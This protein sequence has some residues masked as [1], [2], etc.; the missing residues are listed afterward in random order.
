[1]A[2]WTAAPSSR[3][4]TAAL[5]RFVS[6]IA[7]ATAVGD[8]VK[9]VA[10]RVRLANR[11]C[12]LDQHQEGRLKRILGIARAAQQTAADMQHHRSVPFHQSGERGLVAPADK[13]PEQVSVGR[14]RFT[15]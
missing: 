6:S 7:A 5:T 2:L 4:G 10:Q 11:A 12:L 9:P 8:P 13:T 15:R 14:R 1:M 3:T